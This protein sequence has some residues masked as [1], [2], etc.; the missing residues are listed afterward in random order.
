DYRTFW[1][2]LSHGLNSVKEIPATRW[3]S[4]KYYSREGGDAKSKSKWCGIV[5]DIDQFDAGLFNINQ[6]EACDMDP[7]QRMLLEE[8][9]H[10]IEDS[11][12]NP[13]ELQNHKTGVFIGY[14]T[15]DYNLV[16]APDNVPKDNYAA[17][18]SLKF[19]LANRISYY[20]NLSGPS[21]VFD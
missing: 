18:G 12:V 9:L 20:F 21:L 10:C 8:T 5:D 11:G 7:Q 19:V 14:L 13:R 2:N 6:R 1:E 15:S 3:D 4:R 16:S 17:V